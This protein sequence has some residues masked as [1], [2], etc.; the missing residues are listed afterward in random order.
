M[1]EKEI[2]YYIEQI[3][4]A[5]MIESWA[6]YKGHH[7]IL[8]R[9]REAIGEGGERVEVKNL[10][11]NKIV[12][13]VFAKVVDQ[14][15]N[16]LFGKA[17][18]ITSED[19]AYNDH[20]Q[21]L[22][23]LPFERTLTRVGREA[24]LCGISWVHPFLD[25]TGI[26]RFRRIPATEVAPIWVDGD[27]TELKGAVRK[28]T[29]IEVID[30]EAVEKT[31]I[32]VYDEEGVDIYE[33]DGE[34]LKPIKESPYALIN[35]TYSDE[36]VTVEPLQWGRVPLIAFKSS[37]L[38]VPIITRAK[39]I[40]D[41]INVML[42]DFQNNMMEDSGSTIMVLKNYDG[43]DLGDFRN[44]LS[45]YRTVKVRTVEG[46]DGGVET[47][48]I[49]VNAENY[50][51]ILQVLKKSLIENM[52]GFDASNDRMGQ[53]PNE[54]NIQSAYSDMD[55]DANS[56]ETEF[57][58]SMDE[59][60]YFVDF[61]LTATGTFSVT[62]PYEISILFNRDMLTNQSAMIENCRNSMGLIS[63]RTIVANHPFTQDV[64]TELATMEEEQ[65]QSLADF[66]PYGDFGRRDADGTV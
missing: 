41:A 21:A 7:D 33:L 36:T 22:F 66:D 34:D 31:I 54:M 45:L 52:R 27:H 2:K 15:T 43:E 32:E 61:Y 50:A 24:I 37:D 5:D 64:D 49:E 38:E 40:Q 58:S 6:Y 51:I 14:K 60:M 57:K 4:Y 42:S 19:D 23:D 12:D 3:E 10:P 39:T 55:L 56:T 16:Y 48:Q 11:N 26:L 28:Y 25:A 53:D 46:A 13:N 20:L 59:L 17:I 18:T 47:L 30:G 65:G 62:E 9:K 8:E 63:Q 29:I 1:D 44:N 35:Y